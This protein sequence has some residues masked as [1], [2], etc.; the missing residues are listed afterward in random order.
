MSVKNADNEI[1]ACLLAVG[2]GFS[3]KTPKVVCFRRSYC[4]PWCINNGV[5]S[6]VDVRLWV[7]A[8]LCSAE[9]SRVR[10]QR[11]IECYA[12]QLSL[13]CSSLAHLSWWFVRLNRLLARTCL[14]V[15]C[16]PC[17]SYDPVLSDCSASDL[18]KLYTNMLHS[19]SCT[20]TIVLVTVTLICLIVGRGS[21]CES[22]QVIG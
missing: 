17:L 9:W 18:T 19:L 4:R 11:R 12:Q 5:R 3:W 10:C 8:Y 15:Q 7:L 2:L 22:S 13:F 16:T 6:A 1:S 20:L 21:S 14:C